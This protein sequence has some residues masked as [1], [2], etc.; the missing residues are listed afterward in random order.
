MTSGKMCGVCPQGCQETSPRSET[1]SLRQC[2]GTQHRAAG[3][4]KEGPGEENQ[5][6]AQVFLIPCGESSE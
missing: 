4:G 3:E 6:F 5:C 2:K 1:A